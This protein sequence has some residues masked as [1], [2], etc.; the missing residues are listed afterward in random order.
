MLVSLVIKGTV[1]ATWRPH[2]PASW[3]LSFRVAGGFMVGVAFIVLL[4]VRESAG[5]ASRSPTKSDRTPGQATA[6]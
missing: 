1:I 4:L 2:D 5:G 3:N 6:R